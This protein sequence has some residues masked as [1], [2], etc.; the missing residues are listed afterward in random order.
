M[1]SCTVDST[2]NND[3]NTSNNNNNNNNRYYIVQ[4]SNNAQYHEELVVLLA[5]YRQ[6]EGFTR[7]EIDDLTEV[8]EEA[9]TEVNDADN[10]ALKMA[11]PAKKMGQVLARFFGPSSA[12]V[13]MAV[14]DEFLKTERRGESKWFLEFREFL[15]WAR[16]VRD[17]EIGLHADS[18][19]SFDL[20]GS[21]AIDM[22]E[23]QLVLQHRGYSLTPE[24]IEEFM[25]EAKARGDCA[26]DAE[27]LDFDAFVHLMEIFRDNDG[28]SKEEVKHLQ[29]DFDRFDMDE[30]GEIDVVE[31][32]DLLY[33]YVYIYIY[34]YKCT[35]IYI[36]IYTYTYIQRER[37]R[38]LY[39]LIIIL[40]DKFV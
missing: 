3:N 20:D 38:E 28:F 17:R 14:Q 39:T 1:I 4:T 5:V 33:V 19:K 37:E 7:E 32:K 30:D 21:G 18:F 2:S 36:Y 40:Y 16:R 10:P 15:T 22:E 24:T 27:E 26:A 9:K 6:S 29:A 13:A 8:Y 25:D 35:Y 34:M 31:L 11:L 23:L 12:E